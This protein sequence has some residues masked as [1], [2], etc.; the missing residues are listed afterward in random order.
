VDN[1]VSEPLNVRH[2]RRALFGIMAAIGSTLP[3]ALADS[4]KRKKKK[5]K[6]K[7]KSGTSPDIVLDEF[8]YAPNTLTIRAAQ[9]VSL[10]LRNDGG[11]THTFV[12]DELALDVELAPGASRS[13]VINAPAGQYAIYCRIPGHKEA[14][15]T[16]TLNVT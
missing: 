4:K 6:K 10:L 1:V 3:I 2:R 5:K 13:I 9:D 11:I 12:I 14:G 8:S 15:M 16:G 7:K